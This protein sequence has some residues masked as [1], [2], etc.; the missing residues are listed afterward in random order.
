M[1]IINHSVTGLKRLVFPGLL[2]LFSFF[3]PLS[4]FA[5]IV[6]VWTDFE[7]E[8]DIAYLLRKSPAM[9]MRYDMSNA[10]WMSPINLPKIPTAFGID[11]T[12]IYV[13]YGREIK[14]LDKNGGNEMHVI[15]T[16]NDVIDLL[17]DG[18][19][20]FAN[21]TE[22][23]Y[24]QLSVIDKSQKSLISEWANYIDSLYG[25]SIAPSKNT[26]FGRSRGI[27]PS[28]IT[29]ASYDDA[30]FITMGG[31]SPYHGDY[32]NAEKTWV[33]PDGN[34]V[35][36]SSGTVYNTT[37]LSYNNSFA[38]NIT[39]IDFSGP[40]IPILL[41]EDELVSFSNTLLE[42]G[43]YSLSDPSQ[44]L[45][46]FGDNIFV[47]YESAESPTNV[48][49]EIVGLSALTP[50]PPGEPIDPVGLEYEIDSTTM[51]DAGIVYV[52]SKSFA[53]V[54]RWDTT[55]QSYL[56][57]IP[58]PEPADIIEYSAELNRLY[59][60]SAS[61]KVYQVDLFSTGLDVLPYVNLPLAINKLIPLETDLL[62][63]Y[64][65]SWE[66]Q[67]I[68][69]QDGNLLITPVQCCYDDFHFYVA[70]TR[71]LYVEG[72][73]KEYLG[74]GIFGSTVGGGPY[75][76][77]PLAISRNNQVLIDAPGFLYSAD[78]FSA[79]DVLSNDILAAGWDGTNQ[80][81]TVEDLNVLITDRTNIQ[82]WNQYLVDSLELSVPGKYVA[83]YVMTDQVLLVT[84]INGIPSLNMF[85]TSFE[86][87]PPPALDST[88]L[89]ITKFSAL[90]VYLQW[91]DVQG[92]SQYVL[93][94]KLEGESEW[95]RLTVENSGTTEFV[96]A[97]V[98]TGN[99][100]QY[101]IKAVNGD[102]ESAYSNVIELDL[103]GADDPRIDPTTVSFIPD[104]VVI[105]ADDVIY[106][107]SGEHQSIFTWDI[108]S[109]TWAGTMPLEGAPAYFTYS[110]R[111]E[112][113]FTQ[114]SNGV[115][116]SLN[117]AANTPVEIAFAQLPAGQVCGLIAA[118]DYLVSCEGITN[119]DNHRSFDITG[120]VVDVVDYRYPIARGVWSEANQ[121]IYHFRDGTS[122]NDL[123]ST[124][125]FE[126][127]SIG[128]DQD[129]PYHSSEGIVY[130]IRVKP[131]GSVVVLGS[132]RI[133]DASSLEYIDDVPATFIDALWSGDNLITAT[134][135]AISLNPAPAYTGELKLSFTDK[136]LRIF[137]SR[138]NRLVVVVETAD[139]NTGFFVYDESFNLIEPPIFI[140]GFE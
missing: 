26:M 102:L 82:R 45:S 13:A 58:L 135:S 112:A 87:V 80:L 76:L 128:I 84:S 18:N 90:A 79:I 126:D 117:L 47:F 38:T 46:I 34:R 52:L 19:L 120:N 116:N 66:D 20:L 37:D 125:I 113:L 31:D 96:D 75:D 127:G 55:T 91:L 32:P 68:Y 132:G 8:G 131:D 110:A 78:N 41:I 17:M 35:V 137:L 138:N 5:Q 39:D 33:F 86:V 77:T 69:D 98:V 72:T 94:R 15:N 23:S 40:D 30:G 16:A 24:A 105:S 3:L 62:L 61:R 51:D 67:W 42:T 56:D 10:E 63:L 123:I 73:Y 89:S 25:A 21:R 100:Y 114:Y 64:N 11:D 53:S 83:F 106:L 27:S 71:R 2:A 139:G 81:F 14:Q 29:Y 93:E 111:N 1:N 22:G 121:N 129:S 70:Q 95:Q 109:Q 6:P 104:D 43:S 88:E 97:T 118:D 122:P 103:R 12:S 107:L 28:D 4:S 85:N 134:D 108:K 57:T 60:Y 50:D 36:D 59:I 9:I 44:N 65:G 136:V 133:Y 49:V 99:I 119:W 92:E 101:R 7:V 115:I 130:P 124:Q 48:A 74:S 140:N 54:F